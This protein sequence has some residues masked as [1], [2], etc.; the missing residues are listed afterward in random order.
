MEGYHQG[1]SGGV[2]MGEGMFKY[3]GGGIVKRGV[4]KFDEEDKSS[5]LGVAFVLFYLLKEVICEGVFWF[6]FQ[7]NLL[8]RVL[9][10]GGA[11]KLRRGE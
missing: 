4:G 7:G 1:G 3:L 6:L 8:G 9:G 11:L 10:G 5:Y 2:R